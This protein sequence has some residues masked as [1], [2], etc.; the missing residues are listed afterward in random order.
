MHAVGRGGGLTWYASL[1]TEGFSRGA[2]M[3]E[4]DMDR[5]GRA[6]H[7]AFAGLTTA[8]VATTAAVGVGLA[9]AIRTGYGEMVDAQAAS[10][11][12]AAVL[13]STGNAAHVTKGQIEA[14]ASQLQS[15]TGITDDSI[16]SA[17]NLMLTFTK[18]SGDTFP[19]AIRAAL[20]LSVAF[21]KDLG[22]S[23]TMLGKALQDPVKG[24]TALS[25]VGVSFTAQ[26]KE[27]IKSL[28]ESGQAAKAQTLILRELETQVGGSGAALGQ[29][30]P[31]QLNRLQR[32]FEDITQSAM[33]QLAPSLEHAAD[34]ALTRLAP[35]VQQVTKDLTH[36]AT[37]DVPLDRKFELAWK[38]LD[39]TG[40][41]DAVRRA[42]EKGVVAAATNGPRL[43][44]QGFREAP[45]EGQAVLGAV[46]L[47]K[48]APALK[49]A[50]SALSKAL[51]LAAG[52]GAS[53]SIAGGLGVQKVF[54]V[55]QGFGGAGGGGGVPGAAG[56]WGLGA[57]G[58][59]AISA[60]AAVGAAAIGGLALGGIGLNKA[61]DKG[62]LKAI[63]IPSEAENRAEGE[64]RG[65]AMIEGYRRGGEEAVK[66]VKGNIGVNALFDGAPERVI[67][68]AD[69]AVA[70]F[71]ST[72]SKAGPKVKG[73]AKGVVALAVGQLARL[74][75]TSR[76]LAQD[77][78]I[79]MSAQLEKSGQVPKGTTQRLIGEITSR[80]GA[81]PVATREAATKAVWELSRIEA[82]LL[83]VS[84]AAR[85]AGAALLRMA[86]Q[87]DTASRRATNLGFS[88]G[89]HVP[90]TFRGV[91]DRVVAVAS[92][93][94]ILTPA[95]QAMVPGGR[96]TLDRIFRQT[97]G[98]M[99]G[100]RFASGG[101]V[102]PAAGTT[103]GGGP[104]DH[105]ARPLGN[106]QSDDAWDLMGKDGMPVYASFDGTTTPRPF[107]SN[108]Q[109]WGYAVYLTVPGKG[110][111]Y[112]KHL[113]KLAVGATSVRAGQVLGW[114]GTG[115]NGGPHLHLGA[116]PLSLGEE[117]L[118]GSR[119]IPT[120]MTTA[121]VGGDTTDGASDTD[122]DFSGVDVSEVRN[123]R[124]DIVG[125]RTSDGR[126]VANTGKAGRAGRAAAARTASTGVG[127]AKTAARAVA[128]DPAAAPP[129]AGDTITGRHADD[130]L[131]DRQ[132]GDRV[133]SEAKAAGIT[134]PTKLAALRQKAV[135]Q[136]R[137]G[138][139][140]ADR[141][142]RVTELAGIDA[143]IT[144]L[145]K[146]RASWYRA[147]RKAKTT[148]RKQ[149]CLDRITDLNGQISDQWDERRGVVR[150]ISDIDAE[151]A[152][153][154]Y[155]MQVLDAEI[156]SLPDTESTGATDTSTGST[157][158]ADGTSTL[159]ASDR[160]AIDY[161]GRSDAFVRSMFGSPDIGAGGGSPISAAAPAVNVTV[162]TLHPG[163]PSVLAD[164]AAVVTAA[165]HGGTYT[166]STT[167][168]S[169]A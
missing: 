42:V 130:S 19:R 95:Q 141:G 65:R 78:M 21:H 60:P 45:W 148:A 136:T 56:K 137:G 145:K 29:T 70:A 154:N 113:K 151:L 121:S 57:G 167:A 81:L 99:G 24:I 22:G 53:A 39:Q 5:M 100:R 161:A 10:A 17:E 76:Q 51:G 73:A 1:A 153:L 13:K 58:L 31:G 86:Q 162:Q 96:A 90:G 72:W 36:I 55:N 169:G 140:L 84:S 75:E 152:S 97:G 156:V 14:L 26:Q 79:R 52:G 142:D 20:D 110:Q 30:L 50:G 168:V 146:G 163:S 12:T 44:V 157:A 150:E 132:T 112:Y 159:S 67:A 48:F 123:A 124:G 91:D 33:E 106:W 129:S 61:G 27:T 134:N 6:G 41:P 115:V 23:A 69:K 149:Q 43:L 83:A 82:K 25:R 59:G 147:Y 107:S 138:E 143:R 15:T 32:K 80:F 116:H 18:V 40:V 135:D 101:V 4:S 126:T 89:G 133:E 71:T 37:A 125:W 111:L 7:A 47:A 11:Q 92:G 127:L 105:H 3:V 8:A 102:H 128:Y 88:T 9:H 164:I 54:V 120:G 139:L 165:F 28:V 104:S 94:A 64:R 108:P 87:A 155:D 119:T 122:L 68:E 117:A 118:R 63:G 131:Q 158:A 38:R 2:R 114:L 16:Q 103:M 34:V 160:A 74:P 46:L 109:T 98:V 93:E 66:G 35:A 62:W 85:G 49:I 77:S 144:T 166:P